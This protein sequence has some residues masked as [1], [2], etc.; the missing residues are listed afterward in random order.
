MAKGNAKIAVS[1]KIFRV[2]YIHFKLNMH[3]ISTF[4]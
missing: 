1:N 4:N 2:I 3:K